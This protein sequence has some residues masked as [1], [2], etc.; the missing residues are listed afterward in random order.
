MHEEQEEQGTVRHISKGLWCYVNKTE[1]KWNYSAARWLCLLPQKNALQLK[2]VKMAS[3]AWGLETLPEWFSIEEY[4]S[5]R[6]YGWGRP[7]AKLPLRWSTHLPEVRQ[8]RES[9]KGGQAKKGWEDRINGTTHCKGSREDSD[10][11][12]EVS[13]EEE[14]I[15]QP[16]GGSPEQRGWGSGACEWRV[17][18]QAWSVRQK[19]GARWSH[20]ENASLPESQV[21]YVQGSSWI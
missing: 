1:R 15:S 7:E 10:V 13:I 11:P 4:S 12:F 17:P 8:G 14:R 6:G 19:V 21:T 16:S 2:H 20:R 9:E 3:W 18:T 5:V